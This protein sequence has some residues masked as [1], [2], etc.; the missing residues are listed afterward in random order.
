MKPLR[1]ARFLLLLQ[2][3]AHAQAPAPV[4]PATDAVRNGGFE[5]NVQTPNLWSGVDKD[6]I[7]SGFRG[8]LPVLNESGNIADTP[9][10]V[11][12]AAGDMNGDGLTDLVSADPLG[13]IRIYFNTGSKDQPKF[14]SGELSLPYLALAE[15]DPS[16]TPPELDP[17]EK[18]E[19]MQ[20]WVKRR[21]GVRISVAP[22]SSSDKLDI[23]AGNYFG[24]VFFVPNRG[25]AQ[26]P[27]FAQP[28]SLLA[29]S[30]LSGKDPRQARW[31]NVFAPLLHDWNGDGKPDLLLGEGS[32]SAN[33]IH[34]I[35]NTGSGAAPSF[36]SDKR[37]VLALGDGREQL[38]P[39]LADVNGQGGLDLLVSDRQGRITAYLRP[40]NWKTG[41]LIKPS[42]YIGKSGGITPPDDP[43]QAL[44]LG[45]GV[46]TAASG[47]LNGDGLFD[48]VIGK[49]SGRIAWAPN[50]GSKG[51]PK[52][53]TPTDIAGDKP[54]P[55]AWSL[56]S[57][58]DLDVGTSRGNYGAYAT[59]VSV[60]E[61]AGAD[62]KEGT[63]V[64]KFGYAASA[65]QVVPKP[66]LASRPEKF[67]Q[68]KGDEGRHDNLFRASAEARG[69][70]GPANF[71]VLRQPV[72]LQIGKT[73]TLS[74]QA[75]GNKVSNAEA[76]LGWRGSKQLGEDRLIRGERGAVKRESNTIYGSED[77]SFDFRPGAS[78][79]AVTK[80]FKIEF[81]KERDLNKEK[82]TSEGILEIRFDL[83][84]PDGFLYLDDIK[85]LPGAG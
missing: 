21:Q 1:T 85:L 7:L 15:G 45:S 13:Y 3:A 56:P 79:A 71:F 47:D 82:T 22:S 44:V 10:P 39:T 84:G 76:V 12:V 81:K 66:T 75:K 54:S 78:W 64:L 23:I 46:H 59:C 55:L 25:T 17:Q 19:W 42:G 20:H 67:F 52:F 73:Y 51:Q 40:D 61:D 36:G 9:M 63:K 49:S 58:W 50:K 31:G 80:P 27:Q 16:W 8:F 68:R 18:T 65:N 4:A 72:Q 70:G 60:Q 34:L 6:G 77:E 74:F 30:L 43:A 29:A 35:P 41:E 26:S 53:D 33:S 14:A 2:A 38:T 62:A 37:Q 5:R 57:Q 28:P 24:D 69:A 11:S 32:Y 48:L 83:E